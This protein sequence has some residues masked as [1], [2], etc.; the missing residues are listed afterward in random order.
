MRF[1]EHESESPNPENQ[2][3]TLHNSLENFKFEGMKRGKNRYE[4][5]GVGVPAAFSGGVGATS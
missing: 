2:D 5:S 4:S 1:L 3:S